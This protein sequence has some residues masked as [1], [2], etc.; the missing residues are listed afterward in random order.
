MDIQTLLNVA[1]TG[2]LGLVGLVYKGLVKRLEGQE[3][4]IE[5]LNDRIHELDK[6][7]AGDYVKRIEF[8][9]NIE[10]LFGKL[11]DISKQLSKK[12]DR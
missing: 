8:D 3:E 2:I 7:V 11:D 12:A 10:K 6:I 9:K 4:T 1:F 5:K